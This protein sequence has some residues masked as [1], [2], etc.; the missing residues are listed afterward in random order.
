ME[1]NYLIQ[2]KIHTKAIESKCETDGS[3]WV[4]HGDTQYFFSLL[5]G[6]SF[7]EVGSD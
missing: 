6:L 1:E 5:Y 7:G 2:S 4:K 3:H